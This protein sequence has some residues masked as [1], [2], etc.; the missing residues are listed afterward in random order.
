MG[1]APAALA[2]FEPPLV[3]RELWQW[4]RSQQVLDSGAV[5]LDHATRSPSLRAVLVAEYRARE[6]QARALS[7]GS[8][9]PD[10]A[11]VRDVLARIADFAGCGTDELALMRGAGEGLSL[12]AAALKLQPEDEIV[13]TQH[14]HPAALEPWL[15]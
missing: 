13:T 4:T 8:G 3:S 1:A 15:Q 11:E 14:E 7:A 9:A 12:M 10:A 6:L 2:G 5:Y